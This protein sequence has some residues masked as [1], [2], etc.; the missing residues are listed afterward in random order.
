MILDETTIEFHSKLLTDFQL[1]RTARAMSR[2]YPVPI[3]AYF[4]DVFIDSQRAV[5]IVFVRL[6]HQACPMLIHFPLPKY[7]S[8]SNSAT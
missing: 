8:S 4:S 3:T 1:Q 6:T 5:G 7:V 2:K